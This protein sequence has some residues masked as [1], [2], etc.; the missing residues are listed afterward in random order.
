MRFA[1]T[2]AIRI[3]VRNEMKFEISIN[4]RCSRFECITKTIA[5]AAQ[6]S[7]I[8]SLKMAERGRDDAQRQNRIK[9][10]DFHSISFERR[11]T[12][13]IHTE[14]GKHHSDRQTEKEITCV[15]G[16]HVHSLLAQ[17]N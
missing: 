4:Q 1:I 2:D 15:V 8:L 11:A 7:H 17:M 14:K 13:E 9:C 12:R 6:Q 10:H 5:C 3:G 16:V